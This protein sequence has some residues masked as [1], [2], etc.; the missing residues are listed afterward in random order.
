LN[1]RQRAQLTSG[2]TGLVAWCQ[3]RRDTYC[4]GRAGPLGYLSAGQQ[5]PTSTRRFL[6]F[7][8]KGTAFDIS[9]YRN[10]TLTLVRSKYLGNVARG[11]KEKT[12]FQIWH[13]DWS[14]G[15]AIPRNPQDHKIRNR[16]PSSRPGKKRR[17]QDVKDASVE[18]EGGGAEESDSARGSEV[19]DDRMADDEA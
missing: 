10:T 6:V 11:G 4:P 16:P 15:K 2:V 5:A 18:S 13:D 1:K 7:V 8:A 19:G 12:C 14:N 3:R 9:V 17:R